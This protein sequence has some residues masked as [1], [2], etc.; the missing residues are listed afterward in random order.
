VE[1]VADDGLIEA[2]QIDSGPAFAL[3]VQWHPEWRVTE[4]DFSKAIFEAFGD[5][6]RVRANRRQ[7]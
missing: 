5:A 7:V 2:F 3:A 4:N 6:C 1:A